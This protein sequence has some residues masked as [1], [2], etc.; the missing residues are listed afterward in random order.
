MS[1]HKI[2]LRQ[3]HVYEANTV[4]HSS[5]PL[6]TGGRAALLNLPNNCAQ[7]LNIRTLK[8]TSGLPQCVRHIQLP[9]GPSY[10]V[11]GCV[12]YV[13]GMQCINETL[14]MLILELWYVEH[15]HDHQPN[16]W[17]TA[18]RTKCQAAKQL[19]QTALFNS[20]VKTT[21]LH[22]SQQCNSLGQ[23]PLLMSLD[24]S[25]DDISVA[26]GLSPCCR[27]IYNVILLWSRFSTISRV[28]WKRIERERFVTWG[29]SLP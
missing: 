11:F 9:F 14:G 5:T 4:R 24:S 20:C 7:L 13:P 2:A 17:W 18:H 26:M 12:H 19:C 22:N 10:I 15:Q 6:S 27:G 3:A 25:H 28:N 16:H 23:V 29:R 8:H 1:K 21:I